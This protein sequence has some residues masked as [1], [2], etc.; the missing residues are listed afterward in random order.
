MRVSVV[1][2]ARN[3]FE[4]LP[5]LLS[6]LAD[7]RKNGHE[8]LVVDGGSDDDTVEVAAPYVDKVLQSAPG[9]AQQ[10]NAGARAATGEV[11][12]FLHA[13]S[14][15]GSGAL[16]AL[17]GSLADKHCWGRF[18]VRLSGLLWP[19]RMIERLMN[20]RS[21]LTGLATGD[22]GIF[23]ARWAFESVGGFQQVPLM[24]DI[25]LSSA[26]REI[27]PPFCVH[28]PKLVTS[29][30][31]WEQNGIWKTV[32]LMWWLRLAHALGADPEKLAKQYR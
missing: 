31:R 32:L 22:Q 21:C 15:V 9:R 17:L 28:S 14:R 23:V 24:E 25:R 1:I 27:H 10:L 30:R 18:D 11:L 3:E 20:L 4:A 13:D 29:S 12:W 19:F 16:E 26:L 2:P 6:D 8:I 7:I 5:L